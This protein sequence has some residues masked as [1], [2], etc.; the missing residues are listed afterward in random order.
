MKSDQLLIEKGALAA[1]LAQE[2]ELRKAK[3]KEIENLRKLRDELEFAL[4]EAKKALQKSSEDIK[5]LRKQLKEKNEQ[6]NGQLF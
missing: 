4:E 6:P 3:E 2:T 5:S 1:Q